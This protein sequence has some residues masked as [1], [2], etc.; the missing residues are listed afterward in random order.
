MREGCTTFRK[1]IDPVA[2]AT[3]G[4]ATRMLRPYKAMRMLE[5]G[6][7]ALVK[8]VNEQS[9]AI[10]QLWAKTREATEND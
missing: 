10:V 9:A 7:N 6:N 1:F 4:K 3:I 8:R 5:E 2:P